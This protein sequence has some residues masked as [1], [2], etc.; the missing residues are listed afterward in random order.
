MLLQT[1]LV[2]GLC[3]VWVREDRL[4]DGRAIELRTEISE[5]L[6]AGANNLVLDL[7]NV[8]FLDSTGLGAIVSIQKMVGVEGSLAICGVSGQV[9][10]VFNI[11]R[12]D[13]LFDVSEAAFADTQISICHSAG[14]CFK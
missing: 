13:R 4:T 9:Q 10:R 8:K 12:I 14:Q 5:V 2:D 7:S 6:A 1:E 3:L 11:T